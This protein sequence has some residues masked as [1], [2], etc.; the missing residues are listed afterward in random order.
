MILYSPIGTSARPTQ[1]RTGPELTGPKGPRTDAAE[2][3]TEGA[4]RTKVVEDRRGRGPELPRTGAV[5]DQSD[6]Q[7]VVLLVEKG[8]ETLPFQ[9]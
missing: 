7:R 6:R 1:P 3:W 4:E 9:F 8:R 2:D 5:V